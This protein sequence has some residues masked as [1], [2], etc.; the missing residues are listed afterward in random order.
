VAV[1]GTYYVQALT[2]PMEVVVAGLAPGLLSVAILLVN[3]IRDVA[4]DRNA[5][6]RTLVVR[7]G[8]TGGESLYAACLAG[9]QV[10][11][12]V[13]VAQDAAPPWSLLCLLTL[14]P[15]VALLARLRCREGR[16]LNSVLAQTSGVLL[17]Y[18]VLLGIGWN[19]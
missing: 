12:I 15:S 1:G 6:K 13:L 19:L 18:C 7:L 10:V 9:A 5:G 2:L 3:N 14:P 11:A 17:G 8:R 4:E 16:E